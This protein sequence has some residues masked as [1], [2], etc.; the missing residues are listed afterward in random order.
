[1]TIINAV[2]D[3]CP[4]PVVKAKRAAQASGPNQT[5]QITV[6]NEIA[7]QN[8]EKMAQGMG[9]QFTSQAIAGGNYVVNLVKGIGE[10]TQQSVAPNPE[11]IS[12]GAGTVVAISSATMGNGDDA[13]GASLM[14]AFIFT[15]TELEHLP[16]AV[17]FYNG[18]VHLTTEGSNALEDLTRL[19]E[20]GCHILSC[21][22]CLNFFELKD[23]LQV[24]QVTNMLEI[25]ERQAAAARVIKP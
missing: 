7:T 17:L 21:G 15:L 11:R 3:A 1:M 9:L 23:K 25:V 10:P 20:R 5:I 22:A 4:I 12:N 6:D 19:Q 13:L 24:G 16:S 14:K 18:G 2:G 8:L